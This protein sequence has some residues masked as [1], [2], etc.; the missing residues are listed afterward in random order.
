SKE[1][2][3][4]TLVEMIVVL[5]IIAILAAITIPALLKYIDKAGEKQIVID[6]RTAYLAAETAISEA[7]GANELPTKT[8]IVFGT[9]SSVSS[10]TGNDKKFQDNAKELTGLTTNYKC[11]VTLTADKKA[12]NKIEFEEKGKKAAMDVTANSSWVVSGG[13]I[14]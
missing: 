6:A 7:Y 13:G 9:H 11:T 4:F 1:Q 2:K 12:I 14:S 8:N 5:V 10:E 3:G